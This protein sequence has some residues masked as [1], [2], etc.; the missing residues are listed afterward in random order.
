MQWIVGGGTVIG[1]QL[2]AVFALTA[3]AQRP[4]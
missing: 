3:G 1:I 2:A 4:R